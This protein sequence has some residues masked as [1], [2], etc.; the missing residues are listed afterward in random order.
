MAIL[1][2]V[3]LAKD[4]SLCC[5][6]FTY[7][8]RILRCQAMKILKTLKRYVKAVQ[9]DRLHTVNRYKHLRETDPAEAEQLRQRMA[10]HLRKIDG[11]LTVALG[12]LDRVPTY[13]KK[14]EMQ[15]GVYRF[16]YTV[17]CV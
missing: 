3:Q 5:I 7:V 17:N 13:K 4:F 2:F 9:K 16:Y 14:V 12:M 15:I 10:E 1:W 11:Q 6:A 8:L